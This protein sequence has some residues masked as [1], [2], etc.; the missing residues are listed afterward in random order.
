MENEMP[1]RRQAIDDEAA[2]DEAGARKSR[3]M[4][5]EASVVAMAVADN[6]RQAAYASLDCPENLISTGV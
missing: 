5:H 6:G 3:N 4:R 2:R 1:M